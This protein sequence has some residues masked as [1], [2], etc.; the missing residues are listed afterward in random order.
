ML[1]CAM[2]ITLIGCS[3]TGKTL[4]E[5]DGEELSVNVVMLMMSR[6]KGNIAA[7]VGT[8]A[9]SSSYWDTIIDASA[10]TTYDEYYTDLVLENARSYLAALK[11]FDELELELSDET[12]QEID[13]QMENLVDTVGNG[14]KSYLNSIL[15]DYGANYNVLK[16]AYIL[17]AKIAAL[18]DH[19]FGASGSKIAPEIYEKYYQQN[20]ARFR[21]IFFYTTTPVYET[22]EQGDEIYYSDLQNKKVAYKQDG[23]TPKEENG[24]VVK[25]K[26]GQTVYVYEKDGQMHISYDTKGT[27]ESPVYRNPLLDDDGNIRQT[28]M[29][30]EELADLNILVRDI[31]DNQ[32]KESEY[33]LF[34]SLIEKYNEDEGMEEYPNG[35]YLT[36]SSQY[37]SPEVVEALFEMQVGEIRRVESEWGIHI[38][39]KYELDEGGY[40]DEDNA[41]FFKSKDGT[42]AFMTS[43]KNSLLSE[44][45]EQY[46][47]NVTIDEEQRKSLSMKNV[48][49]NYNY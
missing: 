25:D 31:M 17:E 4:M 41:D 39:M 15:A 6:M 34:D 23:A 20:Y 16:E 44:Y 18:S 35:Y 10:G 13:D 48:S 3:S 22:D 5:L 37:D 43:M 40:A 27:S 19:L 8:K 14:S 32:V 33:M 7:S 42:Y 49:P 29:E 36:E 12:K 21:Q 2:L 28:K 24:V 46:K 26:D 1:A 30:A 38:V 9:E 11:M 45:L 47:P